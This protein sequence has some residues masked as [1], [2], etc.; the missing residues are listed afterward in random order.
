MADSDTE[1]NSEITTMKLKTLLYYFEPSSFVPNS[2]YPVIHY[3]YGFPVHRLTAEMISARF[4]ENHWDEKWRYGMYYKSHYHSTTHEALGVIRGQAHIL[5]GRSDA[6][7]PNKQMRKKS[8]IAVQKGDVLV[9]PAGVAHRCLK[10]EGG[11]L[12]VGAYPEGAEEWDM[13]YGSNEESKR[14]INVAVPEW[15]P[16]LGMSEEG[17]AGL[18]R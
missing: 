7:P 13:N 5:L 14:V 12:M 3:R 18:W 8:V 9:I 1:N 16:L 10:D 11:F 17:L 4:K 6:E 15:D 2:I